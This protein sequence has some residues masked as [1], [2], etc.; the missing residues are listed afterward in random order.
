MTTLV[1]YDAACAA[2][3]A[4]VSVDEVMQI[5]DGADMMRAAAKIA[6][7]R[8]LEMQAI[9]L[10]MRGERKLGEMLIAQKETV[11]LNRGRAGAGRPSL[12]GAEPEQ[13][14]IDDRPT[15]AEV[16]IDRK[17]SSHAQKMASVPEEKFEA[18]IGTWKQ[19]GEQ[20]NA[21]LTTNL[22]D[23]G[24]EEEQRNARRRLATDLS[25]ASLARTGTRKVPCIYF[26]PPWKRKQGITNRSYENHYPT[27]T[28]DEIIAW[29]QSFRDRLLEDAWGFMWIPRAHMFALHPVAFT[30]QID[31][32]SYHEVT[33]KVPLAY[34]VQRAL[35]FDQYSTCFIW[36][37]TDEEFPDDIG[38]G[39]LVRDQDEVLLMFKKGRG[40]PKP[41]TFEIVGSNH[42]ERSKPLG[43]SRKPQYYR[44]MIARMTGGVPVL[45]CFARHDEQFPLPPNWEAWGNQAQGSDA[46]EAA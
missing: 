31:D 19:E 40:L 16:G 4:A 1:K 22:L 8:T 18:L 7:N 17:L 13:R 2:L 46:S 36:T 15:L 30:V 11:G 14:K 34:A 37:K 25:D 10:R 35:G 24:R 28:W 26:D 41:A 38:G 21:R 43:H 32:G 45:E 3:A 42:R 29:A 39:I 5:R 27:M 23:I 20:L 6:K 33:I 44:D 9:E 12:G